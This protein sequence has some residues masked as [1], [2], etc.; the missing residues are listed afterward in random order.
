MLLREVVLGSLAL[1]IGI[2]LV[3]A[4]SAAVPVGGAS[5]SAGA[6][7]AD[8]KSLEALLQQGFIDRVLH[9]LDV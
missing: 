2:A 5:A 3:S 8:P 7:K 1:G 6:K 4:P 9:G